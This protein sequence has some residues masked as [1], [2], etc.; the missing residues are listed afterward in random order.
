MDKDH[1]SY[2][3][4]RL[5]VFLTKTSSALLPALRAAWRKNIAKELWDCQTSKKL[6]VFKLWFL[7][8]TLYCQSLIC[9]ISNFMVAVN[10]KKKETLSAIVASF[11]VLQ[12]QLDSKVCCELCQLSIADHSLWPFNCL[13]GGP[14]GQRI[15]R[16]TKPKP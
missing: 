1:P 16:G 10:H 4:E 7:F 2:R 6:F 12:T 8:Q 14:I 15:F 11:P 9:L 3:M 5:D 13:G